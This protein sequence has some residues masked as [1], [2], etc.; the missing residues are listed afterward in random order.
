MQRKVRALTAGRADLLHGLAALAPLG[1]APSIGGNAANFV[2][3]PILARP[4]P[5]VQGAPDSARAFRLYKTLAE[6]HAVV[7]RF[8]GHEPGCDGCLRITVGTE[9]ENAEVL[10]RI[11]E[12]L[13]E[14]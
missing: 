6:T 3:V 12:V 13:S 4:A 2:V 14:I 11:K 9:A 7:V 8:R 5:G 10:A 1:V